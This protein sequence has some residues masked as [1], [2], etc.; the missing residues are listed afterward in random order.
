MVLIISLEQDDSTVDVLKWLDYYNISYFIIN[1]FSCI[2]RISYENGEIIIIVD[3]IKLNFKNIHFV[4]YRK[5]NLAFKNVNISGAD[6]LK[7]EIKAICKYENDTLLELLYYKLE[8]IENISSYN[9]SQINKLLALEKALEFGLNIPDYL[10]CNT[11]KELEVFYQKHNDGIINKVLNYPIEYYE[12]SYW[13]PSYT[14]EISLQK[15]KYFPKEFLSSFFQEKIKKKYEIRSVYLKGKFYS[16][17]IF[18]QNNKQT[19]IDFR[20]YDYEKPNRRV[21][22]LLPRY[23]ENKTKKLVEYFNLRFCSVDFI[24]TPK[25]R[26]VFLEINP[27]GQFGMTSLPCNY[28]LEKQIALLMKKNNYE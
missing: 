14:E 17:A 13:L 6:K 3:K 1:E 24:V 16:M 12:D 8:H 20:K 5:G 23:I 21:P 25:Q 10:V 28:Y 4:W 9:Y 22:F 18:S 27:L 7:K 26:Y 19:E 11:K 2:E 15:L